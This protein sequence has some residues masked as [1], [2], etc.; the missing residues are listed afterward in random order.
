MYLFIDFS[1]ISHEVD[2]FTLHK[3]LRPLK[4]AGLFQSLYDIQQ[5]LS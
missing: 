5:N 1:K 4:K 3:R 2:G